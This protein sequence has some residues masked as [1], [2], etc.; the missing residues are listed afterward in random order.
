M[1]GPAIHF[2]ALLRKRC[3]IKTAGLKNLVFA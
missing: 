1:K 2:I 3:A